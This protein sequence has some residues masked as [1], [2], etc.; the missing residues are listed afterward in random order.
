M[1]WWQAGIIYQIYPRSFQDTNEDG[2]GDIQGVIRRLPYLVEL[3]VDAIWLSPIFTSPM[4]DFGYDIAD[5]TDVDPLFGSLADLDNLIDAAHRCQL[6][7]IL[8][9]VPNHTSDQHPWFR[10]S[11]SS[12]DHPKRDWYIWR[13][14]RPDGG[15]PNNWLSEFGGSGWKLDSNTDQ[16]YY[17][18][19]LS[20]QPDLNWRNPSVRS[21]MHDVMRFWLRRGIDGF[22]V[23]A[24]WYLLKDDRFRDNPPNPAYRPGGLPRDA[25]V[26]VYTADLPE[27]Q[28]AIAGMRRVVD[29]FPDRVLLGEIYLPIERLVAYYGRNLD[30]VH[31]PFNFALLTA[32]WDAITIAKLVEEYEA[33]LPTGGWPNWVLGNHDRP[34]LASR[35]GPDQARVA[36]MLLM[37]LR[38]TPTL[39]YG[40]EIGMLQAAIAPE[41]VRDPFERNV[42]GIGVGRDGCR[43]PMQWDGSSFAGF[44]AVQPWLPIA[45]DFRE[46]NVEI[47][48]QDKASLYWLYR[49]LIQLRRNHPALAQGTYSSVTACGEVLLFVRG[50]PEDRVLIALNMGDKPVPVTFAKEDLPGW[51]LL[52]SFGDRDNQELTGHVDLRGNEGLIVKLSSSGT[53]QRRRVG[54]EVDRRGSG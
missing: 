48:R 17:H 25:L 14:P 33:A 28:S 3:G 2:V 21:A 37:T 51:V 9:L 13:D 40:D 12:R 53:P 46:K 34:R 15:P 39:Y 20:A 10:E 26:P 41:D 4:A 32:H 38:G 50:L 5:Y 30:G 23:D 19:F 36:A 49:R 18:T 11:K 35:I 31:F 6:K 8:D 47:F 24:V 54:V 1:N 44:S 43:T 22:R 16:Y 27:V 7:L 42:P 45:A 52:S 29:E